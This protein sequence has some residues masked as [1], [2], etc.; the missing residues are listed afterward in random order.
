M[1]NN[2][3]LNKDEIIKLAASLHRIE[4]RV[5]KQSSKEGVIRIWYQG[6][7]PYFDIFFDVKDDA[8]IW[9]QLTLRGKSLSWDSR[10]KRF[11]TG[12]TNELLI[13]DVSFYAA[14]KTIEAD[15]TVDGEFIEV[16]KLILQSRSEEAI[17][18]QALLLFL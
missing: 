10:G 5:L 9:F 14:S 1:Q 12:A 4:Q 2:E 18:S 15:R 16:V 11:Q 13:D 7:E 8:I 3:L 17:F 6:E